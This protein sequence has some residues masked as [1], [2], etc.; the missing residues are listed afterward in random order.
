MFVSFPV[1]R[2]CCPQMFLVA[3]MAGVFHS[4]SSSVGLLRCGHAFHV[5][6]FAMS[7]VIVSMIH[8]VLRSYRPRP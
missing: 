8:V 4:A 1:T 5:H 2:Q 6:C 7:T 3:T